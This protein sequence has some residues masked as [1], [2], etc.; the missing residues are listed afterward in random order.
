MHVPQD[1]MWRG[2]LKTFWFLEWTK[3]GLARK[4]LRD[5]HYVHSRPVVHRECTVV[6][7]FDSSSEQSRYVF[8]QAVLASTDMGLC[9]VG[10]RFILLPLLPTNFVDHRLVCWWYSHAAWRR[11]RDTYHCGHN[12]DHTTTWLSTFVFL[13]RPR[14]VVKIFRILTIYYFR[15][16]VVNIV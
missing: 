2:I 15:L 11:Q 4:I 3:Q 16:F 10:R 5:H 9:G 12:V 13:F 6:D 8:H 7:S 1:S 14:L